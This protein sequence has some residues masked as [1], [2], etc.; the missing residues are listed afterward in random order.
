MF[1]WCF[2]AP[3]IASLGICALCHAMTL[4]RRLHLEDRLEDDTF[5]D[6]SRMTYGALRLR[7]T[8]TPRVCR[9][10]VVKAVVVWALILHTFVVQVY[11]FP[12]TRDPNTASKS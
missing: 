10:M 12:N 3:I 7:C 6:E 1:M 4:F 2:W 9:I 5:G 8:W 11:E